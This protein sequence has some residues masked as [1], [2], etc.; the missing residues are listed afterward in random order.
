ML[1]A[2]TTLMMHFPVTSM[3]DA[4][5]FVLKGYRLDGLPRYRDTR[6]NLSVARRVTRYLAVDGL[7]SVCKVFILLVVFLFFVRHND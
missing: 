7:L 6:I 3:V 4:L 1:G 2:V 5:F